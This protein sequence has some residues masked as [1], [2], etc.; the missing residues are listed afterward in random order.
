MVD[1]Y[2]RIFLKAQA[3][4]TGVPQEHS[5][6]YEAALNKDRDRACEALKRHILRASQNVQKV[7]LEMGA[8]NA[9]MVKRVA[10]RA[11]G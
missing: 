4:D 2:R 7:L 9:P 6:I 8:K 5:E 3:P 10:R 11:A 1:R